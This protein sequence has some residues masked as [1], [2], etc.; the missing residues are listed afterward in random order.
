MHVCAAQQLSAHPAASADS[1]A[2]RAVGS[3]HSIDQLEQEVNELTTAADNAAPTQNLSLMMLDGNTL[4]AL[5]RFADMMARSA[6]SIPDHLKGKPAD[7]MAIAMQ[8]AQWGM[9]PFAVAQKT[10]IVSGRLGYEAQLVN[11]V[12]QASGAIIGSFQYEFNGSGATVSCRVGAVLR[13]QQNVT[14]GEWLSASEVTTKNSPLWKTNPKQQLGYLQVKNW[15]R[16]YAPGAI[17]GVYTA[18]ELEVLPPEPGA[19]RDLPRA[20]VVEPKS[21][22]LPAY[23]QA[24]F[25]KNLPSW[26]NVVESGKKTA[27]ALLA[28][29]QTKAKFTQEQTDQILALG[30]PEEPAS[31]AVDAEW[32]AEY[33]A[34]EEGAK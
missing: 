19:P 25:D 17:L 30:K 22:D 31:A 28:M 26:R 6:V 27:E 7:C 4:G 8:A 34:A 10:H 16:L 11:A 20:D 33:S 14:W 24:D 18:D 1:D 23:T 13:G 3:A 9:N 5:T 2:A 29:L 12:I 32:A 21:A 15:A